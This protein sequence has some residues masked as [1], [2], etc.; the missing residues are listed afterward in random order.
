MTV[1][2]ELVGCQK[3]Q[4]NSQSFP[5]RRCY[6]W[7]CVC[8]CLWFSANDPI[9]PTAPN[10]Y[11]SLLDKSNWQQ[12]NN[13]EKAF[14]LRLWTE[15]MA[16]PWKFRW[17]KYENSH[18]KFLIVL[19]LVLCAIPLAIT[20]EMRERFRIHTILWWTIRLSSSQ[21]VSCPCVARGMVNENN[22]DANC[23]V[24]LN[25]REPFV[26][27]MVVNLKFNK[28]AFCFEIAAC[29]KHRHSLTM[30]NVHHKTKR[31]ILYQHQL[32]V[33][34][35]QCALCTQR[36]QQKSHKCIRMRRACIRCLRRR[37]TQ[38]PWAHD[39]KLWW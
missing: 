32:N 6:G 28:C 38:T 39:A 37:Q 31:I 25:D 11:E 4:V 7:M 9:S 24:P 20:M 1:T 3:W 13:N 15:Q 2:F 14:V 16:R 12:H 26:R 8:V 10:A 21:P 34:R 18:H 27:R 36:I 5:S 33:S 19:M 29:P 22:T 30:C 23:N 17:N 35:M